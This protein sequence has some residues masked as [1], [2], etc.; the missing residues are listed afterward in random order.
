MKSITKI[1]VGVLA[2]IVPLTAQQTGGAFG[3]LIAAPSCGAAAESPLELRYVCAGAHA[4]EY[5]IRFPRALLTGETGSLDVV[6]APIEL[7]NLGQPSVTWEVESQPGDHPYRFSYSISNG[8]NARRAIWSWALVVPAED[9]STVLKHPLWRPTSPASLATNA[10]IA[11]QGAFPGGPELR[12][13]ASLG[14]FARW[15]TSMEE[16][17]IRP[18]QSMTQFV[19]ASAFRPGWTTAYASAGK[20]IELPF[21]MPAEIYQ[22]LA[23]LQRPENEQSAV[24]TIGP[25]FGPGTSIQWI[26][27]DWHLGVQKLIVN[28]ALSGESP[29]VRELLFALEQAATGELQAP[30]AIRVKPAAGIEEKVHRAIALALGMQG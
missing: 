28:G 3:G 24:L 11:P 10:P 2:V 25:K 19:V 1:T 9:D 17:P 6:E 7:L 22:E 30:P 4:G 18:G 16:H 14:K 5:V 27:A 12:R 21:E 13:S 20:G 8:A 23:V 26:A 15:T 29:Y